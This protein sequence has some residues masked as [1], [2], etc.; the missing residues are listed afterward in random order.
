MQNTAMSESTRR[1][2][3]VFPL[4]NVMGLAFCCLLTSCGEGARSPLIIADPSVNLGIFDC[5]HNDGKSVEHTFRF[6]VWSRSPVVIGDIQVDC[7]CT[8]ANKELIGRELLPGSVHA[9]R[10]RV[11][12]EGR[13]GV[14]KA[15]ALLKT[16]PSSP[17]PLVLALQVF[18]APRPI[19][20]PARLL[21][22]AEVGADIHGELKV[23]RLRD[24]KA[25]PLVLDRNRSDFW[26]L[27]VTESPTT[28]ET[29]EGGGVV[30]VVE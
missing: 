5:S 15:H 22:E 26:T 21:I 24:V 29:R 8:A 7:G 13:A 11:N 30:A 14:F 20:S 6:R 3:S 17:E 9:L 25:V 4:L 2:S 27:L 23:S 12:P 28:I 1:L 10:L 18:I 16:E 19:V